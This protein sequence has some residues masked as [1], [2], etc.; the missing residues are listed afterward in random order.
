MARYEEAAQKQ[1]H[2]IYFLN[3]I[4]LYTDREAKGGTIQSPGGGV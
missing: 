2:F 1:M 4:K 3:S